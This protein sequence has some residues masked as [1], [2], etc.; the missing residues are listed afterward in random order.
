MGYPTNVKIYFSS[1][2]IFK[3]IMNI[4][5]VSIFFPFQPFKTIIGLFN[6]IISYNYYYLLPPSDGNSF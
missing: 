5:L 3:T 1:M 2:P 4:L 6:A